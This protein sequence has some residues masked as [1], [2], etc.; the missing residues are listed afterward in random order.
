M[1]QLEFDN[2]WVGKGIQMPNPFN[3]DTGGLTINT[4]SARLH[5]SIYYIL[6]TIPGERLFLPDFGS[7]LYLLVF[8]QNDYILRDLIQVYIKEALA[9]WEPRITVVAI[10]P[11]EDEDGDGNTIPV[12]IIYRIKSTNMLDNYVYPFKKGAYQLG[13]EVIYE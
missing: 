4:G 8:E 11:K 3:L 1:N 13:G 9:K 10:E 2:K 6:S 12:S 7:K 5:Q